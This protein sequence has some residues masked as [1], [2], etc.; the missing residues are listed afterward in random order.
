MPVKMHS[1]Y[2]TYHSDAF[3]TMQKNQ[4][5]LRTKYDVTINL[6]GPN[7]RGDGGGGSYRDM[8]ITG[9]QKSI[10]DAEKAINR[11]YASWNE[12][13]ASRQERRATNARHRQDN[14]TAMEQVSFPSLEET[15]KP[16]PNKGYNNRFAVLDTS[17]L[18]DTIAP[19]N[20]KKP[21]NKPLTGW[22]TIASKPLMREK[23]PSSPTLFTFGPLGTGASFTFDWS[24]E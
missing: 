16:A 2:F 7:A 1:T 14:I 6:Y 19:T 8:I 24:E 18:N 13:Y 10:A 23:H 17:D 11:I 12:E 9:S 15:M 4:H 20:K 22:A 5:M 21:E 3:R